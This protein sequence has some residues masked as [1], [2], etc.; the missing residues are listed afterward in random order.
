MGT[1]GFEPLISRQQGIHCG[2]SSKN[3]GASGQATACF[4]ALHNSPTLAVP[5]TLGDDGAVRITGTRITLNVLLGFVRQGLTPDEIASDVLGTLT[6]ADIHAVLAGSSPHRRG[7]CVPSR[8]GASQRRARGT[9]P[10]QR[11]SWR[12]AAASDGAGALLAVLFATD[13]CLDGRLTRA[14]APYSPATVVRIQDVGLRSADDPTSRLPH[15]C[16]HCGKDVGP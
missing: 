9:R 12:R 2:A 10:A 5:L 15:A 16:L 3:E 1:S 7:G 4:R 13:E 14:L 8:V 6:V 11:V